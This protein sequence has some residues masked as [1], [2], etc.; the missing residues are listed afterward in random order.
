MY[1]HKDAG[2]VCASVGQK[3]RGREMRVHACKVA[4]ISHK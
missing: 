3:I 4:V 1:A 2:F